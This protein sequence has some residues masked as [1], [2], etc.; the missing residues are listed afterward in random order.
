MYSETLCPRKGRK[1]EGQRREEREEGWKDRRKKG[2][3]GWNKGEE[4][5]GE[6]ETEETG[7]GWKRGKSL[8][9]L[10]LWEKDLVVC[11][12]GRSGRIAGERHAGVEWATGQDVEADDLG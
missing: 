5:K 11:V 9:S 1:E 3:W 8:G 10:P 6:K 7:R 4:G 2:I 12:H